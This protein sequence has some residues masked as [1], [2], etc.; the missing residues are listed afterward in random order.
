MGIFFTIQSQF[1]YLISGKDFILFPH[2]Q[3]FVLYLKSAKKDVASTLKFTVYLMIIL[4]KYQN[5][6]KV[7]RSY[8][9]TGFF[10]SLEK[11]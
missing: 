11:L 4:S 10:H 3:Y 7:K 6:S 8:L 9:L 2:A 5:T 1:Y